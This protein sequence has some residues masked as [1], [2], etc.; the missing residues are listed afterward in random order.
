M[1]PGNARADP[2]IT[3]KILDGFKNTDDIT[4]LRKK[5]LGTAGGQAPIPT[6]ANVNAKGPSRAR[7]ITK[8][9]TAN[10]R[11][12]AGATTKATVN[13]RKRGGMLSD[14]VRYT[15]II[16]ASSGFIAN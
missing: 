7:A 4:K 12:R 16:E 13:K 15:I 3:Q 10:K 1:R 8:K 5:A 9:T 2:R 11:N 6:A 14:A